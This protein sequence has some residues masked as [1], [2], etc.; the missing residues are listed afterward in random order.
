MDVRNARNTPDGVSTD[1]SAGPLRGALLHEAR[2]AERYTLLRKL[3]EG[4]M[5]VVFAAYDEELDRRVAIKLLRTLDANHERGRERMLREAKTL[6]RLSHPNIV[7]VYDAGTTQGQVFVAMEYVDGCTLRQWV[8]AR[9]RGWAEVLAMYVQAARGLA[10]AHAAGVV[11]R[12]FKP[13]NVLIGKDGRARVADFGLATVLDREAVT[14]SSSGDSSSLVEEPLTQ[15]GALLGT[16]VYMSPE[17]H[18]R[19]PADA[20]S[21]QFSFCVALYESLYDVRPFTGSTRQDLA[22]QVIRGVVREPPRHNGVPERVRRVLLRGLAVEP[23]WR[24]PSMDAL[25]AA[26]TRTPWRPR[27]LAAGG[28]ALVGAVALGFAL[29]SDPGE[30]PCRGAAELAARAWSPAVAEEVHARILASGIPQAEE[31]WASTQRS[32]EAYT[33]AWAAQHT[34][35]CEAHQ[36]GEQSEALFDRRMDCLRR[37]LVDVEALGRVLRE[38]GGATAHAIQ[39]AARLPPLARCDD[40]HMLLAEVEPPADAAMQASVEALQTRI[41]DV[42]ALHQTAKFTAGRAMAETIVTEAEA[43]GYQPLIAE[44][45]LWRGM[46]AGKLADYA[47]ASR[48]LEAAW[49]TAL[50][51]RDDL[52]AVSAAIALAEL[53]ATQRQGEP[54]RVWSSNAQALIERQGGEAGY[55]AQVL[56]V[57]GRLLELE[58]HLQE[59][60]ASYLEALALYERALGP[61]HLDVAQTL[62][63]I[64]RIHGMRGDYAQAQRYF[65]RGLRLHEQ[66]LG[67]EHP[68]TAAVLNSVA[69][70]FARSGRFPQAEAHFTRA[71]A[72]LERALGPTHPD[73]G[74]TLGNLANVLL[75]TG[76]YDQAIATYQRALAINEVALG[77]RHPKI[78][79]VLGNL[80]QAHVARGE[81]DAAEA[82][83]VR[84]L[85]ILERAHGHDHADVALALCDLAVI[86]TR[87]RRFAEARA[88]YLE[89]MAVL[90][91]V[92]GTEQMMLARFALNL[93]ESLHEQGANAEARVYLQR[94]VDTWERLAGPGHHEIADALLTLAHVESAEH[95]AAKA[96]ALLE[97]ALKI[98]EEAELP[99]PAVAAARF[100]LGRA[101]WDGDFDRARGMQLVRMAEVGLGESADGQ[102]ATLA[103]LR[104][105]LAARAEGSAA[106]AG[107][108]SE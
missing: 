81:L 17:Q 78:A 60:L 90:E 94:A 97:R 67:P 75:T 7:H 53:A 89:A 5:G 57:R 49:W 102:E 22:L 11:H 13:D 86:H 2:L 80:G 84:A 96:V 105:W 83:S 27:W 103:E 92:D 69:A 21:D 42:R 18:T 68:A 59:A 32:V 108:R 72:V 77:P 79:S 51:S 85:D 8:E 19:R 47:A 46:I 63:S 33:G 74:M 37:R 101:L 48:S 104:A 76:K 20:R 34:A 106:T 39:A 87:Q 98:H 58:G 40:E 1:P 31:V 29:T 26:L 30:V 45:S 82:Q 71:I 28:V 10:A 55:Q 23:G 56:A 91:R 50:A 4:G 24:W 12:D 25:T 35:A 36:R 66:L 65:D 54:G 14:I 62:V 6:A 95:N 15:T 43:L 9:R 107:V 3:G 88:G 41:A 64:G 99:A 100:E 16:P 93:G 70:A 44:A 61:E 38:D 52:A 73:V